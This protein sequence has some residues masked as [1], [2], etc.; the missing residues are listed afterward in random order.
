MQTQEEY[1]MLEKVLAELLCEGPVHFWGGYDSGVWVQS[2][3]AMQTYEPW[4]RSNEAIT[5]LAIEFDVWVLPYPVERPTT[6]EGKFFHDGKFTS[7]Y[8]PL[9]EHANKTLAYR[10]AMLSAVIAKVKQIKKI[11]A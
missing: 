4:M 6:M 1:L 11:T 2:E 8:S 10:H 9:D 5:T 7:V 3:G